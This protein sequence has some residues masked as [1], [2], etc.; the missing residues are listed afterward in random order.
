MLKRVE[1]LKTLTADGLKM[2]E[3]T[4]VSSV[5]DLTAK[6]GLEAS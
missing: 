2:K 3:A 4:K 6:R 1:D 5:T